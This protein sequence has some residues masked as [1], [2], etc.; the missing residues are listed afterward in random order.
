[1]TVLRIAVIAECRSDPRAASGMMVSS[2]ACGF[3][4]AA[5]AAQRNAHTGTGDNAG[6]APEHRASTLTWWP[7]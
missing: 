5:L 4:H 1:M 7:R 3:R 2:L 6:L